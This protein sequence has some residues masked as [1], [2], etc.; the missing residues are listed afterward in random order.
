MGAG[1]CTMRQIEDL[2]RKNIKDHKFAK[3]P[4]K[5]IISY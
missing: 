4:G 3:W 2:N 1:L 5:K